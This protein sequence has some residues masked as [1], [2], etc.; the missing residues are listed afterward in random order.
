MAKHT[1]NANPLYTVSTLESQQPVQGHASVDNIFDTA[2]QYGVSKLEKSI[3]KSFTLAIFAGAF[4]AIAFLF[5]IT[6]TTGATD[7]PWGMVKL[8]GGLAFSLGLVLVVVCGGELFTSTV[9]TS[10]AWTQGLFST[11]SLLNCWL[12]V[13]FGNLIGATLILSLVL[14]AK[15][16]L[17]D[18][19]NGV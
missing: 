12:R 15:M 4:I 5:Y 17:L 1:M 14:L 2:N 9:L 6:V 19:G 11:K 3:H 7:A 18:G 8:T 16:P 13:Y 10:I